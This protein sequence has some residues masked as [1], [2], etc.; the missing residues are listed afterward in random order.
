[1]AFTFDISRF[2]IRRPAAQGRGIR[3]P[4]P[5]NVQT[6]QP[7]TDPGLR[8]PDFPSGPGAAA[9]ILSESLGRAAGNLEAEVERR[10]RLAEAEAE[11]QKRQAE[12]LATTEALINYRNE[13][14]TEL[15]RR[16]TEDDPSRP[17]F[18]DEFKTWADE[19][20]EA[21][22]SGLDPSVSELG[23][24]DLRLRILDQSNAFFDEA[25]RAHLNAVQA[26]T[27][28]L[29]DQQINTWAAQASRDPAAVDLL[30]NLSDEEI[31]RFGPGLTTAEEAKARETARAVI[32]ESAISGLID[33][34]KLQQARALLADERLD[35]DLPPTRRQV[36]GNAI[37][38]EQKRLETEARQR[39]AEAKAVFLTGYEDHL[40][41]LRAGGQP[42][43]RYSRERIQGVISGEQGDRLADQVERAAEFGETV[44][45]VRWGTPDE[46]TAMMAKETGELGTPEAFREQAAEVRDLTQIIGQRNKELLN[47]PAAFVLQAPHV[48]ERFDAMTAVG[49]PVAGIGETRQIATAAYAEATLAEQARLG[50]APEQQRILTAAQ[51]DGIVAQFARQPEGGANAADMIAGLADQWGRYWPQIYGEVADDL[52]GAAVVIGA[53]M[54]PGPAAMLAEA[55]NVGKNKLKETLPADTLKTISE[56]VAS[57][58]AGIR[59]TMIEQ[60]GG[61]EQ[62]VTFADNSETLAMLYASRGDDAATAATKAIADTVLHK[63]EV[64]GTFRVPIRYDSDAI[65]MGAEQALA[66]LPAE[67]LDLPVSLIG[68][69]EAEARDAYANAV[70]ERGY[71]VTAPDESGL[72]LYDETRSAVLILPQRTS[73]GRPIVRNPDGTF[74]TERTITV[75]EPGINQG[76][77]TNIPSMFGGRQVSQDEAIRIIVENRGIDPETGRELPSFDTIEQAETAARMRSE[78]INIQPRPYRLTWAELLKLVEPS[79]ALGGGGTFREE[80]EL[81]LK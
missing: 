6:Q 69:P 40:A 55:A 34:G 63:Y 42:D 68:L 47:D 1:M 59:A 24:Q 77:P 15:T 14:N 58:L 62:F 57:E 51:A 12:A 49:T 2:S 23:R 28:S 18:M 35:K 79:A 3:L 65:E 20:G 25:G 4:G 66:V 72:T 17:G 5:E 26:K 73:E 13:V 50:L 45:A 22:L 60:P 16:Q 29:I 67:R 52:P 19:R 76:R 21:A 7:A 71:W 64:R 53:G 54:E 48:R 9:G 74:S 27:L 80:R 44:N 32:V 30:L 56:T 38:A 46:L 61:V 81:F 10:R 43:G 36:L 37:E 8:I 39:A 70:R 11:R 33:K 41:Y 78:S 31:D 75:T